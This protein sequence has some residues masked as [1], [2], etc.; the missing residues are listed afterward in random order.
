L[1]KTH[2]LYVVGVINVG[3][4]EILNNLFET[5]GPIVENMGLELLDIEFTS[6]AGRPI[7][8]VTIYKPEGVTLDDC[9]SVDR[10]VSPILEEMD[11]IPGSY[12]LEV[13]SP[14]LERALKRDKEYEIFS[15]R[16]CRVNLYG[17]IDGKRTFEGALIGLGGTQGEEAVIIRGEHGEIALPR[18]NVSK[19]QLVYQEKPL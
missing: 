8:R 3:R 13:S 5:F 11:P 7:L 1:A 12:S 6:E 14:G 15:G 18:R 4:R 16:A 2:S 10:A 19:V 17:P 9:V